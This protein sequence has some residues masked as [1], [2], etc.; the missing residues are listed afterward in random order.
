M[1][2]WTTVIIFILGCALFTGL[3]SGAFVW[4]VFSKAGKVTGD[5]KKIREQGERR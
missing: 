1:P 2:S 5:I 3:V 4:A